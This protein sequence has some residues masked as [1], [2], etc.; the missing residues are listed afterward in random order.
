MSNSET[1]IC[2]DVSPLSSESIVDAVLEELDRQ[3]VWRPKIADLCAL[4]GVSERSLQLAFKS[5]LAQSP[6]QFLRRRALFGAR[7]ALIAAD[8]TGSC[9]TQIAFDHGFGHLGRFARYYREEFGENPSTT[10]R[11]RASA[12]LQRLSA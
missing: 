8:E 4:V 3:A 12:G 6:S 7:A 10:L 5:V 9:V 2:L 11:S 1:P